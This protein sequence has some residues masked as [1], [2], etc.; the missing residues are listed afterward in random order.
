MEGLGFFCIG[1][2]FD[3]SRDR[4]FARKAGVEMISNSVVCEKQE[5]FGVHFDLFYR[6]WSAVLVLSI[7]VALPISAEASEARFGNE[8]LEVGGSFGMSGIVGGAEVV[9]KINAE[10]E[11][12]FKR[13]QLLGE[14]VAE[15][16]ASGPHSLGLG[17][18]QHVLQLVGRKSPGE[19]VGQPRAEQGAKD[20]GVDFVRQRDHGT[21]RLIAAFVFGVIGVGELGLWLERRKKPNV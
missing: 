7:T 15:A 16:N 19:V 3:N 11:A 21:L 8:R 1:E 12:G 18:G 5:F 6:E 10:R 20:C 9:L 14:G 17:E 4:K 2:Q 13:A